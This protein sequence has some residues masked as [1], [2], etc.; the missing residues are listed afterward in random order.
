MYNS[1]SKQ[2][3]DSSEEKA[4]VI[5]DVHYSVAT[6][7][8]ADAAMRHAL[9][10]AEELGVPL[11]VAGDLL[12]S[13]AIIRAECANA[14]IALLSTATVP[15]YILRGNHDQCSERSKEHALNFLRPYATVIDEAVF[16]PALELHFVPYHHDVEELRRVIADISPGATVIMHQGFLGAAMG[17]YITDRSSLDPIEVDHLNVITGHYHK[18]QTVGTV[19]YIGTPYSI[20]HA[21]ANDGPKGFRILLEDGTLDF[22]P[23][24]LRKHVKIKTTFK[25]L[26]SILSGDKVVNPDDILWLQVT[27]RLF[28]LDSLSKKEIGMQL[29]G[30]QNFKLDLIYEE[31][32]LANAAELKTF[33]DAELLDKIIDDS[34]ETREGKEYLKKLWRQTL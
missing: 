12:D 20:T 21:E 17:E 34:E 6:L 29:L 11:I 32:E 19:N 27:G 15:I 3:G 9:D 5:S 14:L 25:D 4:V 24:G 2:P 13:K 23:C 1:L 16:E 22:I 7:S 28:E 10:K 31:H 30:H 33:T 26:Q 18:R 8:L